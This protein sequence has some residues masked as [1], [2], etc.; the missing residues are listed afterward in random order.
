MKAI[1]RNWHI[2]RMIPRNGRINVAKIHRTL[3]DISPALSVSR[4]TI[5]RD[6]H[7]L[8]NIFPLEYDGKKPQGWKWRKDAEGLDVPGM[9]LSAAL[10]F[11]M[12]EGHLSRLLPHSCLNALSPNMKRARTLLSELDS[13]GLAAWPDKISVVPRTQPLIPPEIDPLVIDVVYEA[14]F[15]NRRFTAAYGRRRDSSSLLEINP[16]GLVF[17]DPVVYLVATCWDYIDIRLYSLHRFRSAELSEKE[18]RRPPEFDLQRYIDE[19][20]LGF[21]Q[22]PGKTLPLEALFTTGAAAHL[23]E[24]RL[25]GGQKITP[26]E[27]GRVL[28]E[29]IVADTPQL[30]WWLLGFG[31]QVEVLEPAELREW[32]VET[33]KGMAEVYCE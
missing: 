2:L 1:T 20:A 28:V 17:N 14:L 21:A 32:M 3:L 5:E 25:S 13:G 12:V 9:D 8:S 23:R 16:L 4:R 18:V 29:A 22:E 24:S 7:D 33:V 6:L 10:T 31:A 30:R 19:G 27:N 15:T 11:R 26:Q